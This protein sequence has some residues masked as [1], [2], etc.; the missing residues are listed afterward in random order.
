MKDKKK[1]RERVPVLGRESPSPSSPPPVCETTPPHQASTPSDPPPTSVSPT[2]TTGSE[3]F[4]SSSPT[5]APSPTSSTSPPPPPSAFTSSPIIVSES[6]SS[7][8]TDWPLSVAMG[9]TSLVTMVMHS[10]SVSMTTT[11]FLAGGVWL[12]SRESMEMAS[13]VTSLVPVVAPPISSAC[14]DDGV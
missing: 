3:F 2:T 4:S 9:T 10:F 14:S 7:L 5:L 12:Q 8:S 1:E 13:E 6:S 11:D